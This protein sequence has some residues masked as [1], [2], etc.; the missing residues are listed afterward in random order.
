M[1]SYPS[2]GKYQDGFDIKGH[3]GLHN[4]HR[5]NIDLPAWRVENAQDLLQVVAAQDHLPAVFALQALHDSGRWSYNVGVFQAEAF[6]PA[7]ELFAQEQGLV[8]GAQA[9]LVAVGELD[10]LAERRVAIAAARLDLGGVE[11][12]VVVARGGVDAEVLRIE[13]LD[14]HL[15]RLGATPSPARH[16]GQQGESAL[17]G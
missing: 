7:I 3:P 4:A 8:L 17:G 12:V 15:A 16:L 11:F 14:N 5:V 6:D 13:R 9:V 1:K 2:T 10:E